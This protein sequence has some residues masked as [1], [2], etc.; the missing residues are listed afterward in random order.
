MKEMHRRQAWRVVLALL[1]ATTSW[2]TGADQDRP[3]PEWVNRISL[4]GRAYLRFGYELG[5]SRDDYNEFAIDRIYLTFRSKVSEKSFVEYTLEGGEI[6]DADYRLSGGSL[7]KSS[8]TMDVQTKYFYY[9][10]NDALYRTGFVRV[11]QAP[12]PW[13]PF[14]EELWGYR[15][16]GTVFADRSGYLGSTDLG[17]FFGG[18]IPRDFG[19][20]HAAFVNGEGWK[21]SERG[22]HKDFHLRVTTFPLAG[23]RSDAK[24]LFVCGFAST[25]SYDD[26]ASSPRDRNRAAVQVGYKQAGAVYLGAEYLWASDPADKMKSRYPSLAARSGLVS[27]ALG[28][29]VYGVLSLGRILSGTDASQWEVLAR[30]DHLDPDKEI[31]DNSLDRWIVGVSH[32][33]SPNVRV[34]LDYETVRYEAGALKADE[35]RISLRAE[36]TF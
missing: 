3:I 34:L 19:T 21:S 32:R 10:L 6:R 22:K 11:G 28:Y 29:S 17:L 30:L 4:S 18:K 16:Q 31:A 23:S 15:L 14:L 1:L 2:A 36:V 24:N 27:D 5:E 12:Q 33:W 20:W 25:G 26:V 13:V 8:T 9:E 7:E 35:E